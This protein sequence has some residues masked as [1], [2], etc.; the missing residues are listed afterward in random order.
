MHHLLNVVMVVVAFADPIP[1]VHPVADNC[2][3]V[4]DWRDSLHLEPDTSYL[5]RRNGAMPLPY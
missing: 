3:G 5:I 1:V 2:N 4:G